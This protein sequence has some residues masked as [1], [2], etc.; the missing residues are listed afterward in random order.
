MAGAVERF[1]RAAEAQGL[2]PDIQTF[3]EGTKTADAAA[4]AV[5][6]DVAQIVKSLVFVL[7]GHAQGDVRP[8]L[9]LEQLLD[10][11]CSGFCETDHE[12]SRPLWVRLDY[13]HR[14]VCFPG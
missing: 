1:R 4:R 2:T 12:G 13:T 3:P 10:L 8:P 9:L 6:C 11:G 14:R 5:G 7:D